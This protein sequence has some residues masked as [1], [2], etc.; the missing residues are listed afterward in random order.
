ML[1]Q[2]QILKQPVEKPAGKQFRSVLNPALHSTANAVSRKQWV[3]L[4]K[5][6]EM[7]I[8]K[9]AGHRNCTIEELAAE[10]WRSGRENKN[11]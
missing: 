4:F 9:K 8:K 3:E 5:V 2:K 1:V 10:H 7:K 6:R 11:L